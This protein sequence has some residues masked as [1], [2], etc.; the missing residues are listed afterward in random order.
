MDHISLWV[1]FLAGILSFFSPCVLPLIP[2]YI[3]FITGLSAMELQESSDLGKGIKNLRKIL[4]ET[5]LFILGFSFI[6]ILLG[7]GATYFGDLIFANRR[8]LKLIGGIIVILFGLHV[9][10]VFNIRLL[11][12]EKRVH[13]KNKPAILF[14]SFFVGVAFAIGWTPCIGPILACI[15]TLAATKDTLKQGIFLL[16]F[17]SAGLATPFLLTGVG[18]GWL[19]GLFSEIKRYLKLISI[20]TGGLL[21]IV[22]I[23]IMT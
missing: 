14:G 10:G 18:I 7:A 15:L 4:F 5:I 3:S 8:L 23:G 13:L 19:L 16:S 1:A 22:G 9:S 12:Y 11:Q 6:F 17:Y 20:V 2:A 21:I